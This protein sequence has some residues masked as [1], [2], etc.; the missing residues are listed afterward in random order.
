[1]LLRILLLVTFGTMPC[2]L[3]AQDKPNL[4]GDFH[5]ALGPLRL[6]LHVVMKP[7]GSLSGSLAHGGL[8][9]G[10]GSFILFDPKADYAVVVLTNVG[11]GLAEIVADHMVQRLEGKAAIAL[12][13]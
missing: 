2:V 7:D 13:D 11:P 10:Y 4:T 12:P 8:T 1:M 5:G 3:L 6:R 9:G